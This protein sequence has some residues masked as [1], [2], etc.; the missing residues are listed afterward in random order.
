M[1]LIRFFVLEE[2]NLNLSSGF[3]CKATVQTCGFGWTCLWAQ[4]GQ[5]ESNT[6]A[7]LVFAGATLFVLGFIANFG[8]AHAGNGIQADAPSKS[9][10]LNFDQW[11]GLN[12]LGSAV[13][14][15]IG[16]SFGAVTSPSGVSLPGAS[17]YFAT[18]DNSGK[19]TYFTPRFGGV[20]LAEDEALLRL[21]AH[22]R[23]RDVIIGGMFGGDIDG[24][25]GGETLSWDAFGRYDFG[26]LSIGMEYKYTIG[27]D[28]SGAQQQDIPGTF[29]AGVRYAFTPSMAITSNF[30]YGGL[31]SEDGID[32]AGVAG[33]LGFSL[34]F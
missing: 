18:D 22:A 13:G 28:D 3:D 24:G 6:R 34:N 33:V 23:F 9:Y 15:D 16:P 25:D 11:P 12:A 30:V 14:I 19:I 32:E 2:R 21:G 4:K 5:R 17:A 8:P 1:L 20:G 10:I 7:R 31:A 26:A 27:L 29:Q